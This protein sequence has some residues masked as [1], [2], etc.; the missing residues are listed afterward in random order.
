MLVTSFDPSKVM[1]PPR[2]AS[3]LSQIRDQI[4][5][6]NLERA[7]D[8][9]RIPV[10]VYFSTRQYEAE[11]SSLF[12]RYPL[13]VAH[14]NDLQ[15]GQAI[16]H[17]A[18]GV[19][20]LLTR[21]ADGV[22]HCFLNVCR[23]RGMRLLDDQTAKTRQ[24]LACPYHGWSYHL[25]GKFRH[26][27]HADAFDICPT[28]ARDLVALPCAERAGLIWVVPSP[29]AELNL[30]A[31]LGDLLAELNYYDVAQH[32]TYRVVE[33]EYA[34]NWKLIVD[35]FLEAYHIR[36]L[37]RDTIHPFF[38]DGVSVG[39]L[40]E[41]SGLQG[42]HFSSMVARRPAQEWQAQGSPEPRNDAELRELVTP[43]HIIFP[44]TIAIYHPDYVSLISL[45]P[46]GPE[47]LRWVHR[48]L[49]PKEKATP[50][51]EA[52]WEKTLALIEKGV[53]QKED[54][55]TAVGIQQGLRTGANAYLTVGR[56]EAALADFHREV[57]A[58]TL[59]AC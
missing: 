20:L 56:N 5:T 3:L 11:K 42:P 7:E 50:G 22:V 54:I 33:N 35:A 41:K 10:E 12:S 40:M 15:P 36:V 45:F 23:H 27:L 31:Y 37:H 59:S 44:N 49:I 46:T 39:G 14:G 26:M 38:L 16:A 52:H 29:A 51:W 6:N 4:A 1:L 57:H 18:Y 32:V 30:D 55:H 19:P 13:I 34:A 2:I 43:S 21:D 58:A 28:G 8:E 17:D 53:F 25:N 47:S 24:G 48:M 9:Q